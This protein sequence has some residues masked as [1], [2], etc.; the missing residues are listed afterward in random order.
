MKQNMLVSIILCTR[1][2]KEM[3]RRICNSIAP[4]TYS[5][6]E[7]IV[8]DSSDTNKTTKSDLEEI[9]GDNQAINIIYS[10]PGLTIQ[11]NIGLKAV[12]GDWFIF[13]DDDMILEDDFLFEMNKVFEE[14]KD[15]YGG[16]GAFSNIK[17]QTFKNKIYNSF[18]R[19]FMLRSSY[20]DGKFRKSGFPNFPFGRK[21]FMETEVLGG[22]MM[23]YRKEIINEFDFDEHFSNYSYMED[24]DFSRRVS[25]KYKLFYNP[26]ARAEHRHA[27]GGRGNYFENRRMYMYNHRYLFEK[28]FPQNTS[29]KLAHQWSILGLYIY[30]LYN[31]NK[32]ALIAIKAYNKGLKDY[33]KAELDRD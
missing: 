6:Y 7:L 26:K 29:N 5:N 18:L 32:N 4:Q 28:N 13:F 19:F 17:E 24:V 11:R 8:V 2:R 25:Q 12:T 16:M 3:L 14:N 27:V 20:G 30:A 31:L 22:A 23:A 10:E 33:R 21:V 15:Y 1:N 9:F